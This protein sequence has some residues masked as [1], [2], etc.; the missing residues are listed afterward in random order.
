MGLTDPCMPAQ[1]VQARN[2]F[3]ACYAVS[4]IQ[5]QTITGT[6]IRYKTVINY[7]NDAYTLFRN[8]SINY[9][10]PLATDYVAIITHA[11]KK[12]DT[13]PNRRNMITD[14]M[15]RWLLRETSK[16]GK[17]SS[18]T[19][20]VDWLIL[21]RYTGYRKSEWCQDTQSSY[22]RIEDWPGRPSLAA[23]LSDFTF[24]DK[25]E[26]RIRLTGA[27]G[28]LTKIAYVGIRWRHQKNGDNDEVITFACDPDNPAFCP[29][30]AA[31]RIARRAIRLRVPAGEPIAVF[32]NSRGQRRFITGSLV[33]KQL[34]QAA[35]T[36]LGYS[37]KDDEIKK[38][39][40]HSIRVT[41]ANLLH[42]QKFTDSYIQKRLRWKS[43][44]FLM[45]LRNTFYAADQHRL[46]IS[47]S[48]LPALAE[49]SYRADE[50][51]EI[52]GP[53]STLSI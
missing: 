32:L 34:R 37:S 22:A 23:I 15:M 19:A 38:W 40:S 13:V 9:L 35:C 33:Q 17:D 42:R 21:G 47:D 26:R 50:A 36:V 30:A 28:E 52:I 11:F 43:N 16:H 5:G 18:F 25:N 6:P 41:A 46:D 51:H 45:Y 27:K 39:S 29:V 44:S 48:N 8:R 14:S 31:Y 7:L 3:L 20:I 24:Y 53:L 49:R 4:L 2:Y 12:Y 1:P 10:P